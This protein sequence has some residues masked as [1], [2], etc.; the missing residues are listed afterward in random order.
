MTLLEAKRGRHYQVEALRSR[1]EQDERQ[2]AA[3]RLCC[4]GKETEALQEE[5]G[6]EEE[7]WP[8][9][10]ETAR[11]LTALGMVRGTRLYILHKKRS[12]SLVLQIRGTRL[13]LGRRIAAGI[14][15]RELL[16]DQSGEEL[17]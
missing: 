8:L 1:A 13:A 6:R 3:D 7:G 17:P 16:P 5:E 11:R 12:G 4:R 15:V 9:R 10:P 2:G 14:V